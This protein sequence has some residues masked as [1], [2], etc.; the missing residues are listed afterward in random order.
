MLL[1]ELVKGSTPLELSKLLDQRLSLIRKHIASIE[2]MT[3]KQA[4]QLAHDVLELEAKRPTLKRTGFRRFSK[5]IPAKTAALFFQ[6][7]N[8]LNA[9]L[10]LRLAGRDPDSWKS[11]HQGRSRAR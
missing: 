5:V 10:D 4:T 6:L 2:S 3:D 7:E 1:T 11:Q 9:A 8:Q